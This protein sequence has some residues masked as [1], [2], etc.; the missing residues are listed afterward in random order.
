MTFICLRFDIDGGD[1]N[2]DVLGFLYVSVLKLQICF[3]IVVI[4]IAYCGVQQLL[5]VVI[6]DM[7]K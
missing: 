4:D 2:W 7:L 6:Y 3:P 5:P 1:G